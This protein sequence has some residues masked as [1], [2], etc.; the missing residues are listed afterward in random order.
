MF[1]GI[2]LSCVFKFSKFK[3]NDVK[4]LD[5]AKTD[6]KLRF[7]ESIILKYDKQNLYTQERSIPLNIV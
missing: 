1:N 3:F 7:A 4:I 6:F 5:S 2:E